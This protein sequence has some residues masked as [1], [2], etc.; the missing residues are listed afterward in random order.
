M[1]KSTSLLAVDVSAGDTAWMLIATAMVL[2]MTPGLAMFYSGMVRSKSALNMMMLCLLSGGVVTLLW[3]AYGFTLVFGDDMQ[4]II[5]GGAYLWLDGVAGT[6]IGAP[7]NEIP[8]MVFAAFQLAFAV[9]AVAI[10]A[11]SVADRIR[12]SAWIFFVA[13]WAT[14]VYFPIAHWVFAPGKPGEHGG[15]IFA[16][17]DVLDFAGGTV[18]HI[19]AAAAG[20]AMAVVVGRRLGWRRDPMRPHSMPMVLLGT[21]LLWFGWFGFN[22]GSALS[23]GTLASTVLM[24]TQIAAAAGALSWVAVERLR[25]TRIN[26]LGYASGA[27]AG[28]VAITPACGFV[29]TR[30]ALLAGIL[31]GGA[32][33]WAVRW[34]FRWGL[35]DSLDVFGIHGVGGVIGMIVV[36][37]LASEAVNPA[38]ADGLLMGGGASLLGREVLATAV[39]ITYSFC[40]TWLIA[41]II[42]K[43]VGLRVPATAELAGV[44]ISNQRESAYDYT[45]DSVGA[46]AGRTARS[47]RRSRD[48][49]GP[50]T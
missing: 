30:G 20:L 42:E 18:I 4:G 44:D 39:V 43:T 21:S 33:A 9:I 6:V 3:A 7:G 15:W 1:V 11:G 16:N 31:A 24:N 10:V 8:L 48:D 13:A 5:G 35:D 12:L 37:L 28:L 47:E 40:V 38:G 2:L 49:Q 27:V 23:A 34:K 36:G 45:G 29:D 46:F 19:N 26:A 14:F 22:A 41:V 32:C 50:S 17:L 25:G